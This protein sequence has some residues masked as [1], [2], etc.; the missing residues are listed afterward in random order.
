[1]TTAAS[2]TSALSRSVAAMPSMS[3]M[4][5][6]IRTTSGVSSAAS[7]SA[8]IPEDGRTDHLDVALETEQLRQVVAGL[9]NVVHDEDTDLVGH[10]VGVFRLFLR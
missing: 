6:S 3:G 10:L 2:G 7:L 1:M 8:S 9:R 4:L 5:M